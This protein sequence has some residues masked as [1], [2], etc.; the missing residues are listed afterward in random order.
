M[1]RMKN[2]MATVVTV[3]IMFGSTACNSVGPERIKLGVDTCALCNMTI[4]NNNFG[5]EIIT[6]K[7]MAFKFD[8]THCLVAFMKANTTNKKE[9]KQTYVVNFAE[10]HNFIE[11]SKAMFLKSA[12]LHSPMGGNVASFD[13]EAALNET[14]QKVK[15][16]K[17]IWDQIINE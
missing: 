8:D 2:N 7:G 4:A 13:A 5:A 15:G 1:N 3:L 6:K 14:S 12:E 9:I 11:V 16:E 10:P 17:I